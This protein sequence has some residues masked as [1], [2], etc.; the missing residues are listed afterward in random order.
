MSRIGRQPITIEKSVEVTIGDGNFI[1]VK[2]PKGQLERQFPPSITFGHEDG[3]VVVT[4]PTDEGKQRALHGLSRTLLN[5]MV[6]GVTAG[7]TK[8]LEVQGVGYRA[9][10]QG[11]N[12]QLALGFSHPVIVAPPPGITFA[13]E[14]PRIHVQGI[15]KEQV[16]Q[17]AANIRKLRPPEPYKG[18]G[19]RYMGERVRR[20]AG[21]A[22]K[23]GK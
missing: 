18:K 7:F 14:G 21:K 9:Q 17:V 6:T 12:L 22:G 15:D 20:K 23:V 2:G 3:R 19:V 8:T 5:N 13:V 11:S 10:L 1:R 16:G 4:R